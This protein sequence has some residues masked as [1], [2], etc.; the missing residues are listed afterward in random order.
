MGTSLLWVYEGLTEYLGRVLAARSGLITREQALDKMAQTAAYRLALPGREWRSLQDTTADT[1][2]P[3]H[4]KLS[5]SDWQRTRDYYDEMVLV[6]LDIDTLIREKSNERKSLDHLVKKFFGD[7]IGP[8]A[9]LKYTFDD[10]VTSLND[11]LPFGWAAYLRN[12]LDHIGQDDNHLMEGLNRSGWRLDYGDIE[13]ECAK[14]ATD[15]G[16]DDSLVQDLTWSIGLKVGKDGK[17]NDIRW[18]G[19]AFNAGLAPG[20]QVIAIN[21]IDSKIEEKHKNLAKEGDAFVKFNAMAFTAERLTKAIKDVKGKSDKAIQL[22]VKDGDQ[23]RTVF[24]KYTEGLRYP[25]LV[26]IGERSDRLAGIF[27]FENDRAEDSSNKSM[28]GEK[29]EGCKMARKS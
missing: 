17:L 22:F 13:S 26:R 7:S 21:I 19:P 5:W 24:I 1:T 6:W 23:Y 28:R 9:P 16:E 12:R 18:G 4:E 3:N 8:P 2:V 14:N 29:S 27:G 25:M 10:I 20:I 11:V 15:A